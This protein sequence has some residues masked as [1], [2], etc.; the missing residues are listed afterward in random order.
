MVHNPW[1]AVAFAV[2]LVAGCAPAFDG[3]LPRPPSRIAVH[4]RP[5]ELHVETGATAD[6]IAPSEVPGPS[7]TWTDIF[8]TYFGPGTE[9]G[10]GR[11]SACHAEE[12][13]DAGST[14]EWLSRRGYITGTQSAL[15]S[16]TNSCL[17][18]FGGNMPPRGTPNDRATRDLEAWVAGGALDN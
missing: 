5:P 8:S 7:R 18:W 9:G 4:D 13:R 2:A 3:P 15:V 12:V 1:P 10:C 16:R 11:S 14:Y 6:P 17:R